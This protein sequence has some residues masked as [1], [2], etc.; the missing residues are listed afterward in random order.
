MIDYTSIA[1]ELAYKAGKIIQENFSLGMTREL[2]EKDTSP[3]TIFDTEI[4]RMVIEVLH[5]EFPQHR[6]I[7][8]E[9]SHK[10]DSEYVWFCDPID[11][12]IPFTSGIPIATFS[13]ALTKNWV[14]I[15]GV[16]YDP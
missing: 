10:V 2:K 8:E 12:T 11:G 4:N 7:G 15:L 16:I 14:P 3:V 1:T 9:E 13:L 5:K 6:I